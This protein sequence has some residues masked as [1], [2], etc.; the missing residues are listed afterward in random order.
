MALPAGTAD[1]TEALASYLLGNPERR[2][3]RNGGSVSSNSGPIPVECPLSV[4]PTALVWASGTDKEGQRTGSP[5]LSFP[6]VNSD[7]AQNVPGIGSHDHQTGEENDPDDEN[8]DQ[9]DN[10]S[11][12]RDVVLNREEPHRSTA[13][14]YLGDT[15][16]LAFVLDICQQPRPSHYMVPVGS[17][18]TLSPEE[19]TFL[20]AGGSFSLPDE[21]VCEKLTDAYFNHIHP[22]L[23][24]MDAGRFLGQ[25]SSEGVQGFSPLLLWSMFFA[26]SSY[27]DDDVVIKAGYPSRKAMK[28]GFFKRAKMLYDVDYERDKTIIIQSTAL[29]SNWFVDSEDRTGCWHWIGIAISLGHS[30]GLHR[31]LQQSSH[32]ATDESDTQQS[33][34]RSLWWSIYFR[35]AWISYGM[36]RPMRIH[37][38]DVDVP[39]PTADDVMRLST[40]K[41]RPELHGCL[42]RDMQSLAEYWIK[43]LHIAICITKVQQA[44]Y[45]PRKAKPTTTDIVEHERELLRTFG[46]YRV[47]DPTSSAALQLATLQIEVVEQAALATLYRPYI[48]HRPTDLSSE[49]YQTWRLTVLDKLVTAASAAHGSLLKL[50]QLG[51]I[52]QCQSLICMEILSAFRKTFW[53]ADW[54]Y[55]IFLAAQ[56]RI[57]EKLA[58]CSS[59]GDGQCEKARMPPFPPTPAPSEAVV[60]PREAPPV[61]LEAWRLFDV[62]RCPSPEYPIDPFP[63]D[64]ELLQS[65]LDLINDAT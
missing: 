32:M 62:D 5:G 28:R 53:H 26:A 10:G 35:E 30:I 52:D 34:W 19:T 12:Y 60:R 20:E 9:G 23:P 63:Q 56:R 29:L 18:R 51:L 22:N 13:P 27:V 4:A 42:P 43:H 45:A 59:E 64:E 17:N 40:I 48:F 41:D 2:P 58:H 57:Q 16:V 47:S 33:L 6:E 8:G 3:R 37:L 65:T 50:G 31:S 54:V 49:Q 61:E 44:H 1:T 24:I 15:N 14:L 25:L 39:M 21:G 38:A 46:M 36:G 55:H 7:W 11:V